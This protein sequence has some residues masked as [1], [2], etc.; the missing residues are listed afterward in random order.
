M[1]SGAW[2]YQYTVYRYI[3]S[4]SD[5][6][7]VRAF[8]NGP[9]P[10]TGNIGDR[11]PAAGLAVSELCWVVLHTWLSRHPLQSG[12]PVAVNVINGNLVVDNAPG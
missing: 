6:E 11:Y 9:Q 1:A 2:H 7:R 5:S 12:N 8:G 10:K 4:I 3:I